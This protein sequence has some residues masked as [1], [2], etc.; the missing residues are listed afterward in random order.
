MIAFRYKD[1]R[2]KECDGEI[3]ILSD[4]DP[5]EMDVHANGWSFH[6]IAG[7]HQYGS[8]FLCIP[9]WSIGS[10]LSRLSDE[11]W[12]EERLRK[13]TTL[14][15]DNVRAIVKALTVADRWI[16]DYHGEECC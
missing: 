10:E 13:H 16:A 1:S 2:N 9:N 15:P 4:D 14:H 6:V 12:N 11:F 8:R 3:Q 7:T 5:M